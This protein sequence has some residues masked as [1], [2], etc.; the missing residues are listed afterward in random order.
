[1][2]LL[3]QACHDVGVGCCEAS[4]SPISL[5]AGHHSLLS[6]LSV[7]IESLPTKFI[8]AIVALSNS[9]C[10]IVRHLLVPK[11][12][13]LTLSLLVRP[14]RARHRSSLLIFRSPP[15]TSPHRSILP[16]PLLPCLIPFVHSLA[17]SLHS[18]LNRSP[19]LWPPQLAMC[20]DLPRGWL[21]AAS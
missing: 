7:D 4:P 3:L 14:A 10:S 17:R 20:H 21:R 5:Q 16:P 8:I 1:M 6:A 15:V 19:C 2:Q 11:W 9:S 18:S 13:Q 12:S